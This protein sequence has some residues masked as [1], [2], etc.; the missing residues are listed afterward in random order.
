MTAGRDQAV[1]ASR[2][3][4]PGYAAL[5]VE[6]A[7]AIDE[8][9]YRLGVDP[10]RLMRVFNEE[11]LQIGIALRDTKPRTKPRRRVTRYTQ[12]F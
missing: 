6:E 10:N 3:L 1:A 11:G 7:T 5:S 2:R 9:A 8:T 4:S 12:T